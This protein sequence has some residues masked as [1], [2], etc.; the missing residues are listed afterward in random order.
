MK[1]CLAE[2]D[3]EH[4]PVITN[5]HKVAPPHRAEMKRSMEATIEQFK[6]FSEGFR[7][8]PGEVYAAVEAPK[9]EFGV[10]LV[11]DGTNHP[12]RCKIR[13]PS[14]PHLQ[15]TDFLGRGHML[16]DMTA[17]IGTLDIV[18]GEIDR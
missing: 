15:A 13:A 7:V 6:L 1:Q 14:F 18:F 5:N 2:L 3:R 4:G 12:Y 8:P 10:Y 16:A 11:S 17:I 9:G